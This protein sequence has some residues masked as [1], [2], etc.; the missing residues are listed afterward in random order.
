MR[1]AAGAGPQ[2][3]AG[4]CF[5]ASAY[6]AATAVYGAHE[7]QCADVASVAR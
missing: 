6:N 4:A 7:R 3:S 2:S 1:E 5:T